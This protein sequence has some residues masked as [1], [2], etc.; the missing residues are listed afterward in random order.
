MMCYL[1]RSIQ[2]QYPVPVRWNRDLQSRFLQ[3][4][5]HN[6]PPCDLL[7]LR[8]TTPAHK[9]LSPSGIILVSFIPRC[10]CWA[11]TVAST[12]A[13]NCLFAGF[14]ANFTMNLPLGKGVAF[15]QFLLAG[16]YIFLNA[17]LSANF[18]STGR[19]ISFIGTCQARG[20]LLLAL[21]YLLFNKT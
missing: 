19:F 9:G 8:D 10:P 5:S 7:M 6:K 18:V 1:I 2:P 14:S 4:M 21:R 15:Y 11:H 20:A 13:P 17:V 3:C 12:N 16:F